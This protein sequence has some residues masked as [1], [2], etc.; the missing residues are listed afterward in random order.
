[1]QAVAI[2]NNKEAAKFSAEEYLNESEKLL[3]EDLYGSSYEELR[4]T[5]LELLSD[6]ETLFQLKEIMLK[7]NWLFRICFSLGEGE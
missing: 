6:E 2:L 3:R 1:M 7:G 5:G 4:S